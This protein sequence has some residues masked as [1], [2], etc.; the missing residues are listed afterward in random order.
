MTQKRGFFIFWTQTH[1][2]MS[3]EY[4]ITAATVTSGDKS[5]GH[6]LP[7]NNGEDFFSKLP[8]DVENRIEAEVPALPSGR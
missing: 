7:E 2:A 1:I 4:I 6:E 5:D 8:D 3:D